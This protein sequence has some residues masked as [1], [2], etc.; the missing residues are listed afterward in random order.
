MY[1]LMIL[2]KTSIGV[3]IKERNVLHICNEWLHLKADAFHRNTEIQK[4]NFQGI[5]YVLFFSFLAGI[6][7]FHISLLPPISVV[8]HLF[9]HLD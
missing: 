1:W 8:Y 9:D 2:P 5:G 7:N 6:E 3:L 4:D